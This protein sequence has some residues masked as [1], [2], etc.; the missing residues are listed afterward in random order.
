MRLAATGLFALAASACFAFAFQSS[1]TTTLTSTTTTTISTSGP[2]TTIRL[3]ANRL[4]RPEACRESLPRK[5]QDLPAL[6]AVGRVKEV[7]LAAESAPDQT[8]RALINVGRVVKGNKQLVGADIIVSG[9]N[10]S[11]VGPTNLCPNYVKPNDTLI[12]LLN[13]DSTSGS[14]RKYSIQGSNL[15]GMNLANLDRI[16]AIASDEPYKRRQQIQDILC[17][18]HYCPYGRCVVLD[19]R[20]NKTTCQCPE[21]CAPIA[22]PVCGSDN[23][24][25]PNECQLIFEGCR[26]QRPLFVTKE[27]AC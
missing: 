21:S 5:A 12:L 26:R 7:Y 6:V 19:E 11:T 23:T 17:E 1:S 13:Q 16:N 18:A 9:F 25:Y 22:Q 15:L 20:N 8:N 2:T 3:R 10:S 27:S 4:R 24:T 14:D